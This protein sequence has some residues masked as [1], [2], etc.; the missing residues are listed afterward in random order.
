MIGKSRLETCSTRRAIVHGPLISGRKIRGPVAVRLGPV[1]VLAHREAPLAVSV[2]ETTGLDD[3]RRRLVDCTHAEMGGRN[4]WPWHITCV[5][6]GHSRDRTALLAA[7]SEELALDEPWTI[8]K[9]SYLELQNGRYERRA[10]WD[11]SS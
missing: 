5:R 1:F 10:E 11:L 8:A 3:A 2:L 4:E 9:V 6:Y 7:A